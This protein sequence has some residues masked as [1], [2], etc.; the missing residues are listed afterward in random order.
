MGAVESMLAHHTRT[1]HTHHTIK[2]VNH[3]TQAAYRTH[4]YHTRATHNQQTI[5]TKHTPRT[6]QC[7]TP[8]HTTMHNTHAHHNPQHAHITHA[9]H[10]L[11][12]RTRFA[13]ACHLPA[14]GLHDLWARASK[15]SSKGEH[16]NPGRYVMTIALCRTHFLE[17]YNLPSYSVIKRFFPFSFFFFFF[18]CF[19]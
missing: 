13:S 15:F 1:W 7:T 2:P 18:Y 11:K 12:I 17:D 19:C 14:P 3:T 4:I 6:S 8:T 10:T 9:H 16:S 5:H